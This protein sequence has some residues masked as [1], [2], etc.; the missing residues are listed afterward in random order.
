MQQSGANSVRA[1]L[2]DLY[3]REPIENLRYRPG[4]NPIE[5]VSFFDSDISLYKKGPG[6]LVKGG[7]RKRVFDAS[8]ALTKHPIILFE[9]GVN[10]RVGMHHPAQGSI[11]SKNY[12]VLLHTKFLQD[13][14][15]KSLDAVDS[16]QFW[17]NSSEYVK[18]M[19]I[20][21][22]NVHTSFWSKGVSMRYE[23]LEQL[24]ELG[25]CM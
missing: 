23:N 24:Q 20:F 11:F 3:S 10:I 17:D 12:C 1:L 21:S 8:V 2:L 16:K 14:P 5:V 6:G 13:C 4:Q 19:Q 22:K 18:Y 7:V 25:L 9:Q 15:Q